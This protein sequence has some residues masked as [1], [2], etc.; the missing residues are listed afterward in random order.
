MEA[1][2]KFNLPEDEPEFKLA[3]MGSS[4]HSVLW[5]LDQELRSDLKHND[6]LT[7]QE[8]EKVKSIREKLHE[9]MHEHGVGFD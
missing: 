9:L 7:D 4:Y 8:Y 2:L 1:I 5:D 3:L 6:S